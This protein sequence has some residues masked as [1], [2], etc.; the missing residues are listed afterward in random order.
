M[1]FIIGGQA[2]GSLEILYHEIE[3]I[4]EI[5]APNKP[6]IKETLKTLMIGFL[7]FLKINL[8]FLCIQLAPV[9]MQ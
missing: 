7:K 9:Q 5:A 2:K 3:N 8:I 1:H 6:L 4:P